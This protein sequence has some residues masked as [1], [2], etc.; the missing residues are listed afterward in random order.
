MAEFSSIVAAGAVFLFIVQGIGV[1][2]LFRSNGQV[3]SYIDELKNY[4]YPK[5][6]IGFMPV[7]HAK[8]SR[9]K[10]RIN[11]IFAT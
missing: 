10:F 5:G 2:F 7:F 9:K 11:Y 3:V 6:L 1:R 8:K 4:S